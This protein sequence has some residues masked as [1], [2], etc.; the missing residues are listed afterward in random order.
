MGGTPGPHRPPRSGPHSLFAPSWRSTAL[1]D[2]PETIADPIVELTAQGLG[3]LQA[4][5]QWRNLVAVDLSF[6]TS[7]LSEE[8]RD[9]GRTEGRAAGRAEDI[10]LVLEQRGIDVPDEARARITGCHDPELLRQWLVRAVTTSSTEE[11]F[12]EE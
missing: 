12:T 1:R 2:T 4:A 10:L 5:Q 8:I 3:R 6:Y 9:E 7:P 11:I